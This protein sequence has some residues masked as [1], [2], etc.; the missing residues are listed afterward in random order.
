MPLYEFVR[1]HE[2]SAGAASRIVNSALIRFN[3]FHDKLDDTGRSEKFAS[4]RAIRKRK[5]TEEVLVNPSERVT[6]NIIGNLIEI[7]EKRDYRSVIQL[8][9]CF[10]QD[11]GKLF[12]LRLN[13]FHCVIHGS[14][15]IRSLRQFYEI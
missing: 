2:H 4:A 9:K 1:L 3:D 15:H 6:L 11:A 5:L 10:R 12:I 14:A 7:F 8:L 13:L